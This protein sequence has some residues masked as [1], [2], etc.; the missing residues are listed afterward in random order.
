MSL[1]YECRGRKSAC[2][3]G[4]LSVV[5]C[6]SRSVS[7]HTTYTP[8]GP[9]EV[10]EHRL[11]RTQS[12]TQGSAEDASDSPGGLVCTNPPASA[13]A[14]GSVT[15]QGDPTCHGAA[16]PVRHGC[17]AHRPWSLISAPGGASAASPEAAA[18]L[19]WS[20]RERHGGDLAQ[21]ERGLKQQANRDADLTGRKA[22]HRKR[23][24]PSWE[25][26]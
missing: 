15:G 17:R 8:G 9:R 12:R 10:T 22:S 3:S 1:K 24:L 20:E 25:R 16:Q 23:S 5:S 14:L 26:V 19:G 2:L 7:A 6:S 13:G 4:C 11:T 18:R 21:P